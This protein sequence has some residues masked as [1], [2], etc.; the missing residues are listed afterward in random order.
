[1][2]RNKKRR[3]LLL[4]ISGVSVN[5]RHFFPGSRGY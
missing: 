5:C 3:A 1:M 4:A 2:L